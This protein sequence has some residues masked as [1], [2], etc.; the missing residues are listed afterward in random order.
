MPIYD[1]ECDEC[2]HRIEELLSLSEHD[3]YT[4]TKCNKC[5]KGKMQKVLGAALKIAMRPHEIKSR[6]AMHQQRI[7]DKVRTINEKKAKGK[8]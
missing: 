4:D 3:K 7:A 1:W 2:E 5:K 6:Q 8:A